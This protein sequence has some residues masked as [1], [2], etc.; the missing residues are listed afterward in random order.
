MPKTSVHEH[1]NLIFR[2]N[3]VRRARQTPLMKA[4]AVAPAKK[5]APDDELRLGVATTDARHHPTAGRNVDYV[6]Q[7]LRRVQR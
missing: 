3:D 7:A 6:N 1:D 4:V 2:Q 5:T